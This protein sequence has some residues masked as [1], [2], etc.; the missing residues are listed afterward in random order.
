MNN[1]VKLSKVYQ[2]YTKCDLSNPMYIENAIQF[3]PG[4]GNT[5]GKIMFIGEAPGEQEEKIG[6]PFV[7]KSGQLLRNTLNEHNF[8]ES[9]VFI[10]NVVKFRPPKNRTPSPEEINKHKSILNSEIE[11]LKPQVIVTVGTIATNA[12]LTENKLGITKIRGQQFQKDN[13]IIIP[14]FHPAYILRNPS[15]FSIFESDIFQIQKI[16]ENNI[17]PQFFEEQ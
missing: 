16:Y 10:T 7:G 4:C 5:E 1:I 11:I 13:I 9:N 12:I 15:A 3:V 2:L 6:K 14:I 8:N 17:Y